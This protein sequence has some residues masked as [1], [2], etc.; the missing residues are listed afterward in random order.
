MTPIPGSFMVR[1]AGRSGEHAFTLIE[2]LIAVT[3][4]AVIIYTAFA[5]FRVV[6]QSVAISKRM[7][8]E[9]NLLRTGFFAALNELDFWDLHDDRSATNPA[10][11]PFRAAGKPFCPL[12]YDNTKKTSD[13]HT[14]WRGLGFSATSATTS[15][16]GN[17]PELSRI[18][19]TDA[20]RAWYPNQIKTMNDKLG[21]YGSLNYL[22]GNAIFSWYDSSGITLKGLGTDPKECAPQDIWERT[23]TNP[24]TMNG[25][26][27]DK[28][29]RGDLLPSRP[30]HWA[31][32]AVE[33]RR[34]IVWSSF[35]D[36]CQVEMTS[37]VTGETT[38]LS[39]WGVGTTLRGARQQRSRPI[40]AQKL[41]TIVVAPVL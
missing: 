39:F 13:P 14:W 9:N 6:G 11:N 33:A 12:T 21:V 4:S 37:P 23:E 25:K 24:I 22:P 18:G 35:I 1:R 19:H 34:Y 16:W 27:F 8:I 36:L 20:V 38:R 15:P 17:Y 41:D 28:G 30:A 10:G 3:L 2:L 29:E 5:A 31:G 40:D 26:A 32:L 7:S